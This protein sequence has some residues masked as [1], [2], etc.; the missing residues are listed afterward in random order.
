MPRRTI[1]PV[2]PALLVCVLGAGCGLLDD[3]DDA[4]DA[5]RFCGEVAANSGALTQPNIQT[6][7]DIDALLELYREIGTFA[8]L[9]IEAEWDQ[10]VEAYETASAVIPGDEQS[11][12]A[13]IA[14]ILSSESAAAA[15]DRWLMEN[16]AVDIGP[17]ATIVPQNP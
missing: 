4:G 7:T 16:C 3:D 10:L 9:A 6:T 12:Q 14:A 11:E 5:A 8:P 15:V 13:A 1:A 17:V 2:V